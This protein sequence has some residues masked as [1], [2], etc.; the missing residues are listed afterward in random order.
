MP[1]LVRQGGTKTRSPLRDMKEKG[2]GRGQPDRCFKRA[3]IVKCRTAPA[4]DGTE[5]AAHGKN[6][7][8]G[9]DVRGTTRLLQL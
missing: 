4:E 5:W 3:R 1:S 2:K 6:G 7:K 9:R 8:T